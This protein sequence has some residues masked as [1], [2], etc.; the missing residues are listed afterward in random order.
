[1]THNISFSAGPSMVEESIEKW[2]TG[3][4]FNSR[5]A[6]VQGHHTDAKR[7]MPKS[8]MTAKDVLPFLISTKRQNHLPGSDG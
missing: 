8:G 4:G 5:P 1:M 7:D 3:C 6:L 2:F